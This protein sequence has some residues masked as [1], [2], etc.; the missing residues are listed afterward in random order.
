MVKHYYIIL[1]YKLKFGVIYL[2]QM[3][4][5]GLMRVDHVTLIQEA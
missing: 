5:S 2:P 4:R 1:L 3:T